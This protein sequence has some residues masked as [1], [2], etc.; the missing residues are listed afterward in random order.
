[1]LSLLLIAMPVA[2]MESTLEERQELLQ[3]KQEDL[4]L[5]IS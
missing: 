3:E 2:P 5:S 4:T 1:M